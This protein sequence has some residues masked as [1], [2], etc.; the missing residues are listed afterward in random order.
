MPGHESTCSRN[1]WKDHECRGD[2]WNTSEN[3]VAKPETLK[4]LATSPVST[5]LRF[6]GG[7]HDVAVIRGTRRK[8]EGGP[9]RMGSTASQAAPSSGSSGIVFSTAT[10]TDSPSAHHVACLESCTGVGLILAPHAGGVHE[11]HSRGRRIPEG[12][13][14]RLHAYERA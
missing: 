4:V 7:T 11:A 2:C 6:S 1:T 8:K 13:C 3:Q 12:S 9:K 14:P 5:S 10:R